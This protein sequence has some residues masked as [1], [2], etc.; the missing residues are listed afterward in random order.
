M[1]VVSAPDGSDFTSDPVM[2]LAIS[3]REAVIGFAPAAR[4]SG[5]ESTASS[6]EKTPA[7]RIRTDRDDPLGQVLYTGNDSA[8]MDLV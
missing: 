5:I 7:M 1:A 6:N 2:G 8:I 4:P 3:P